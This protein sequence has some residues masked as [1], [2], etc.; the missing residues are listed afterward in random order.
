[1]VHSNRIV[2]I[3]IQVVIVIVVV[4]VITGVGAAVVVIV[5]CAVG[6]AVAIGAGRGGRV[7][8]FDHTH[9]LGR[10]RVLQGHAALLREPAV[11]TVFIKNHDHAISV[12]RDKVVGRAGQP[13]DIGDC[14]PGHIAILVNPCI[15]VGHGFKVNNV[16]RRHSQDQI[17]R[18][19]RR[20]RR[21]IA[22]SIGLVGCKI[23]IMA[24][25]VRLGKKDLAQ[26]L[27]LDAASTVG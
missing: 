21:P 13:L 3:I 6:T 11:F 26:E 27:L 15:F 8:R 4:I 9:H 19:Q 20:G 14:R 25:R 5:T 24:K 18:W 22:A 10:P 7:E 1:M 17:E 16:A 12:R 23:N 2:S